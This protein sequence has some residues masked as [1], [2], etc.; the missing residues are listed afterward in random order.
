MG[1][2]DLQILRW[3]IPGWITVFT[4][5]ILVLSLNKFDLYKYASDHDL[6]G[7]YM[8]GMAALFVAAGVPLGYIVYQVYFYFKWRMMKKDK[9]TKALKGINLYDKLIFKSENPW[10]D[11]QNAERSF[12]AY[13]T[14][15][16]SKEKVNYEDV[17]RRYNSFKS[18]TDRVHGLGATICG[19]ILSF[20]AFI[21]IH[22]F[23][24][25]IPIYKNVTF[26]IT[27]FILLIIWLIIFKNYKDSNDA[28]FV[29]MKHIMYDVEIQIRSMKKSNN[30]AKSTSP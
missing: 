20:V 2:S 3:G 6:N 22:I 21:T 10:E 14:L 23:L 13:L 9:I 26:L 15:F 11:W 7:A 16:I 30:D 28:T 18:R 25:E 5:S 4:Y 19:T 24:F 1:N 8:A 27:S 29:Q 17:M 12:D